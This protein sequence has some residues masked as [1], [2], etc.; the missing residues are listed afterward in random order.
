MLVASV[1]SAAGVLTSA[2]II[3][4]CN[5]ACHAVYAALV[6]VVN[7]KFPEIGELLLNRVVT[8]VGALEL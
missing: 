7:T 6:G 3:R 4:A 2:L 5:H 8:Q 1:R